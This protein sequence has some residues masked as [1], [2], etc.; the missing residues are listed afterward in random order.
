MAT[1]IIWT[2]RR[3]L[4]KIC[5]KKIPHPVLIYGVGLSHRISSFYPQACI[6]GTCDKCRIE[7]IH[8]ISDNEILTQNNTEIGLLEWKEIA[9]QEFKSNGTSHTHLELN[10]K[11]LTVKEILK[12]M[13]IQLG[14]CRLHVRQY[15]WINWARKLDLV[16]SNPELCRVLCTNFGAT[17]DLCTSEKYNCSVENHAIICIFFVLTHWR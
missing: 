7:K 16:M 9:R 13:T 2:C 10:R 15:Q 5:C 14:M 3:F 8:K 6:H 11:N 4:Q 12:K 1:L 17:L